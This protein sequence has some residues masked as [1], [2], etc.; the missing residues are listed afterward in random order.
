MWL[1]YERGFDLVEVSANANPP[2]CKFIDY[3]KELYQ[4]AKQAR[5]QKAKQKAT[6]VK[7]VKLTYNISV[8]DFD[9]RIKKAQQ[10]FADGDKVRVSIMLRGRENIF[11]DKAEEKIRNFVQTLGA[12]YEMPIKRMGNTFSALIIKK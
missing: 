2:V 4:K 1:A 6:E 3:N 9:V 7:E 5:K 10:F 11:R 8:H 12:S